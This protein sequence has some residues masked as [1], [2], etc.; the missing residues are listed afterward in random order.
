LVSIKWTSNFQTQACYNGDDENID[1]YTVW[2]DK[3]KGKW[4]I[5]DF[6]YV[7]ALPLERVHRGMTTA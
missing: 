1:E 4:Q 3:W 7:E 5:P 2:K 6:V